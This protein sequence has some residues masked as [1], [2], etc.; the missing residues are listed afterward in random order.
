MIAG[1]P[2]DTRFNRCPL[3]VNYQAVPT[4]QADVRGLRSFTRDRSAAFADVT[5]AADATRRMWHVDLQRYN[6]Q[7][8]CA[9]VI[10][11]VRMPLRP[12]AHVKT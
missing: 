8:R 2:G 7:G 3:I 10:L 4:R 5:A 1:D 12:A 6:T 9:Y 11:S